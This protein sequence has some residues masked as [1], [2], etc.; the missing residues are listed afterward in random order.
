MRAGVCSDQG[1]S[2]RRPRRDGVWQ[3]DRHTCRQ[4]DLQRRAGRLPV[5]LQLGRD[6]SRSGSLQERRSTVPAALSRSVNQPYPMDNGV[7]LFRLV[8]PP[9]ELA[10]TK[11]ERSG[12]RLCAGS[13]YAP[14]APLCEE[15]TSS[16]SPYLYITLSSDR[17]TTTGDDI[18]RKFRRA[19][20]EVCEQIDR[21]TY[22]HPDYFARFPGE[23]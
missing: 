8:S 4:L 3:T 17:A 22:A 12:E 23:E 2:E 11:L 10:Q 18:S 20:Y 6:Q 13:V 14:M 16:T 1:A 15:M 9:G 5:R 7:C 21:Q 19:V